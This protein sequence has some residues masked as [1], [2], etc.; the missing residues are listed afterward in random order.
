MDSV[1]GVLLCNT[2]KCCQFK[3]ECQKLLH[4]ESAMKQRIHEIL[5]QYIYR[6]RTKDIY[7]Y[8]YTNQFLS[9]QAEMEDI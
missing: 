1:E 9:E 2:V 3:I 8:R 4:K 6:K 7:I 5:R